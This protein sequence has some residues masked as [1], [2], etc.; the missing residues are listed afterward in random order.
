MRIIALSDIHGQLPVI[1]ESAEVMFICGDIIPLKMQNNYPQSLKWLREEFIPH[2]N[3]MSVEQIYLIAGNHDFFFE[4]A[5]PQIISALFSGTKIIYLRNE[6]VDYLDNDG[7]TI[8]TQTISVQ[9]VGE[10]DS[11][12]LI[13]D[14]QSSMTAAASK[15]Y[16]KA[17]GTNYAYK[18]ANSYRKI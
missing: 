7:N 12:I 6:N 10:D 14:K 8:Y 9:G 13:K 15:A 2:F 5:G 11:P 16:N 18:R 4:S 3:N 17:F 1:S